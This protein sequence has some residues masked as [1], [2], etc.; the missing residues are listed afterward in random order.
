MGK[1]KEPSIGQMLTEPAGYGTDL[2]FPRTPWLSWSSSAIELFLPI[3]SYVQFTSCSKCSQLSLIYPLKT[4]GN[5]D[6]PGLQRKPGT[7]AL[8]PK[9]TPGSSHCNMTLGTPSGPDGGKTQ[10]LGKA[11]RSLSGAQTIV[12]LC[13]STRLQLHSQEEMIF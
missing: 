8:L 5:Q 9:G 2:S 1:R 11:T 7:E 13:C 3:S 10:G 12:N 4:Y 6:S